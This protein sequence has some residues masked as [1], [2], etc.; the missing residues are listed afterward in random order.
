MLYIDEGLLQE[1]G[2]QHPWTVSA[3]NPEWK[4]YDFKKNPELIPQVLEDFK[5]FE[6][7]AAI[8]RFYEL[9]AWLNGPDSKF[10]TS[11]ARFDGIKPNTQ[12]DKWNKELAC[13]GGFVTL[14]RNLKYNL[15]EDSRTWSNQKILHGKD[16]A[17][18][19]Q[20]SRYLKWMSEQSG[21]LI[22][23][24]TPGFMYGC[25]GTGFLKVYYVNGAADNR[26][27][28]GYQ[29]IYRFWAWGDTEEEIMKN[30]MVDFEALLQCVKKLSSEVP[31][32]KS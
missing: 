11:D 21:Y 13:Q 27:K 4:Y 5:P 15:S 6:H 20:P 17:I 2:R 14:Y 18:S 19:Y 22:Q 30:L 7:Y 10:E 26:D 3:Q 24:I 31:E 29:L 23:Q 9:V 28:F 25:I 8:Q 1:P 12:K 16:P 32:E